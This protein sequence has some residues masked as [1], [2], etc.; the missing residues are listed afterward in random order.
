[1]S[2]EESNAL[3]YGIWKHPEPHRLVYRTDLKAHPWVPKSTVKD[4][5]NVHFRI[6]N[7]G[8]GTLKNLKDF[9]NNQFWK[10]TGNFF[11][12]MIEGLECL[13]F[14]S[15]IR[16]GLADNKEDD[17]QP[18][19]WLIIK[20]GYWGKNLLFQKV[21][22]NAHAIERMLAE[23]GFT[24]CVDVIEC[25][26]IPLVGPRMT[27]PPMALDSASNLLAELSTALGRCISPGQDLE[28]QGTQ[29][30]WLEKSGYPGAVYALTAHHVIEPS[31]PPF[32][33][34]YRHMERLPKAHVCLLGKQYYDKLVEKAKRVQEC[35]DYI[36]ERQTVILDD[37]DQD[38]NTRD[39]AQH[40]INAARARKQI[41]QDFMREL[42]QWNDAANR[43]I[44][45]VDVAPPYEVRLV[46][47]GQSQVPGYELDTA[48]IAYDTTRLPNN[49]EKPK[50]I[51]HIGDKY[52]WLS[53]K[54]L[55][56]SDRRNK[57]KFPI[58]EDGQI[59]L[60]NKVVTVRDLMSPPNDMYDAEGQNRR[61]VYKYGQLTKFTM[62]VVNEAV[63]GR[64]REAELPNGTRVEM[65][66][67]FTVVSLGPNYANFDKDHGDFARPGDSGAAI[68]DQKRELV[69]QVIGGVGGI[70]SSPL[71]IFTPMAS[72]QA[73][74]MVKDGFYFPSDK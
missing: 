37:D 60:T 27:L 25:N 14:I 46:P 48:I 5:H 43:C 71:T 55:L 33:K 41:A 22:N 45:H 69:G 17:L 54:Q 74:V 19:V 21:C 28:S 23:N 3:L 18:R 13:H 4:R 44:G 49:R 68:G 26:V 72:I 35:E 6:S 1:M 58:V 42:K 59:T 47:L 39:N 30:L 70:Y 11:R 53:V 15:L 65:V 7:V 66:V 52:T 20:P 34:E 8:N 73:D 61:L 67:D 63:S 57:F 31:L 56:N 40:N 51:I 62:G 32:T 24:V 64:R 10:V 2:E 9:W 12:P 50:N 38:Q 16:Y 36:I 29:G